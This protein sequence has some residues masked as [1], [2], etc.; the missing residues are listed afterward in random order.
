MKTAK[1]DPHNYDQLIFNKDVKTSQWGKIVL[2]QVA[3]EQSHTCKK[4]KLP[5]S[6]TLCVNT[7]WIIHLNIKL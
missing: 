5:K 6:H 7:K 1:I 2:K 4:K 3:L